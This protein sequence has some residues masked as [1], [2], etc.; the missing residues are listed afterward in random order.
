[1]LV[2]PTY[3]C[4]VLIDLTAEPLF[5]VPGE[6]VLPDEMEV[7]PGFGAELFDRRGTV[8]C[9]SYDWGLAAQTLRF[10][11]A[12][13][14]LQS[15]ARARRALLNESSALQAIAQNEIGRARRMLTELRALAEVHDLDDDPEAATVDVL[16]ALYDF[17]NERLVAAFDSGDD[18]MLDAVADVLVELRNA[19]S[20]NR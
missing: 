12:D 20:P 7:E 5:A 19:F 16:C 9:E 8:S 14:A 2:R 17:C 4:P 13:S 1:M 18:T 6:L 15:L 11:L 3:A 10:T